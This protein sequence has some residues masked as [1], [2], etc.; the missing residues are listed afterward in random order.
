MPT[1]AC[2][3]DGWPGKFANGPGRGQMSLQGS[4]YAADTAESSE[5]PDL[6][7]SNAI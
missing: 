4:G 2:V 3:G 5:R 7:F 1:A 6:I